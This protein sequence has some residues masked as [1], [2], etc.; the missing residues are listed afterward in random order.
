M[1]NTLFGMRVAALLGIVA[2]NSST[3]LGQNWADLGAVA[4]SMP[5][6][7]ITL[8]QGLTAS[9]SEGRPISGKFDVDDGPFQLSIYT[10][11]GGQFY[12]VEVDHITGVI[13]K[14]ERI[15]QVDNLAFAKSQAV[16][17][18][19]AKTRLTTAIANAERGLTGYRA[20]SV[21][22]ELREGHTIAV[23]TLL[24]GDKI[25]S[26]TVSLE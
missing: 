23:V 6:A 2:L 8:R 1:N 5:S 7:K 4:R 14:T 9:E 21:A 12:K 11:K 17:M 18:A 13:V 26:V 22:P 25:E 3:T 20:I 19:K 16:A 15:S 24:K 10:V